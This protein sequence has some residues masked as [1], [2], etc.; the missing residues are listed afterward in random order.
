MNTAAVSLPQRLRLRPRRALVLPVVL[1]ALVQV[2]VWGGRLALGH[3][4]GPRPVIAVL[5][6]VTSLSLIWCRR[7][8]LAVLAFI[9]TADSAVHLVFGAPEGLGT[10]LPLLFAF[11]AVGATRSPGTSSSL[12]P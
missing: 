10:F 8:P 1:A 2:D 3:M 4:I 11:Y 7:A 5:F 6:A 12:H 9:V